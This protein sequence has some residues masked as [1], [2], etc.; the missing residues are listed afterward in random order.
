MTKSRFFLLPLCFFAIAAV[1]NLAGKIWAPGLAAAVKPALLPLLSLTTLSY[2]AQR[3]EIAG[4]TIF[5]LILAQ[6][7]GCAGDT[8]LLGSKFIITIGGMLSFI[9]GHICYITIF[10]S[11]SFP[12]LSW[13]KWAVAGVVAVAIVLGLMK[14]IG[15]HGKMTGPMFVYAMVLMTLIF[16][17][18]A[19]LLKNPGRTWTLLLAGA[20]IFTC[21]DILVAMEILGKG[22]LPLHGFLVMLTYLIAQALLAVGTVKLIL[23]KQ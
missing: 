11:R 18:L 12:G 7:F 2:L 4:K 8:F 15:V 20:V 22:N 10:G 1:L 17:T 6:I 13:W 21:S 14:I 16:S 9:A 3:T 19:G 23:N 5:L